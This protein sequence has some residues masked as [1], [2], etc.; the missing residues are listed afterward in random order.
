MKTFTSHA[1]CC[2]AQCHAQ[3]HGATQTNFRVFHF[4]SI[5]DAVN[6]YGGISYAMFVERKVRYS[7]LFTYL[8]GWHASAVSFPQV[9]SFGPASLTPK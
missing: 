1:D 3:Y 7:A 8:V 9:M 5:I 6:E 4:N 2:F